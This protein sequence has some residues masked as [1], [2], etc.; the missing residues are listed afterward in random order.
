MI[1]KTNFE[2]CASFMWKDLGITKI[3]VSILTFAKVAA[4]KFFTSPPSM[5]NYQLCR[6]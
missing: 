4:K 6:M 1:V 5:L 2:L 3:I